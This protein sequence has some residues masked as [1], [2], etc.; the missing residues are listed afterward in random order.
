MESVELARQLAEQSSDAQLGKI[1]AQL[2]GVAQATRSLSCEPSLIKE[3][4]FPSS[5]FV[6]QPGLASPHAAE[7]AFD[8]APF[9]IP[10]G[11]PHGSLVMKPGPVNPHA[12][13]RAL[14]EAPFRMF[15]GVPQIAEGDRV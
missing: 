7:R 12:A 13:E 14:D 9:R 5:L 11:A 15:P 8:K 4:T 2:Q 3:S 6:M 10:P 1:E